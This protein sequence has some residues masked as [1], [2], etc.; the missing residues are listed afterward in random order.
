MNET[1]TTE[2]LRRAEDHKLAAMEL[3]VLDRAHHSA[4]VA[5]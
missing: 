4:Q 3:A 2:T 5:R 1:T